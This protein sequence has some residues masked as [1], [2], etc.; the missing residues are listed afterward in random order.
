MK[1]SLIAAA[2]LWVA[3]IVL[4]V[5]AVIR[6]GATVSLVLIVPVVS[7]DSVD[8]L[9]GVV[10]II[11]GFV[12]L[13]FAAVEGGPEGERTPTEAVRASASGSS[14]A[15]GVVLIGP[16]PIVFGSWRGLSRRARWMLALVGAAVLIVVGLALAGLWR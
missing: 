15:G 6:G 13:L 7:G 4:V 16:I 5:L 11:A 2:A 8:F 1:A 9:L 12:A 10:L 3:G 14:G